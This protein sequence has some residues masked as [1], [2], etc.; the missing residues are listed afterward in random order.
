M[1]GEIK[2][3]L[4]IIME[5]AKGL[6]V[7]EEEKETFQRKEVAGKVRGLLQKFLDALLDRD[8]FGKEWDLFEDEQKRMAREAL[9]AECLARMEPD[10][11]NTLLLEILEHVESV[12]LN[13][14]RDLLMKFHKELEKEKSRREEALRNELKEKGISGSAVIPNIMADPVWTEYL[15]ERR[16]AF[17]A[18]LA[19][20]QKEM[21][22]LTGRLS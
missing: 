11:D 2:S 5:R 6:T 20:L 15:S 14:L 12:S 13:P 7:T 19:S 3:T 1:M 22:G 16:E 4:D 18:R 21:I 8:G 17:H 9:I 10:A